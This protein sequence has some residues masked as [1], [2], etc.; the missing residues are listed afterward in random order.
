MVR[1]GSEQGIPG[2]FAPRKWRQTVEQGISCWIKKEKLTGIWQNLT[3]MSLYKK[4]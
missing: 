2:R 3:K 1:M 4:I